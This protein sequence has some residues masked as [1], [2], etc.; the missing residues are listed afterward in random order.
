MV[1]LFGFER[2]VMSVHNQVRVAV[3]ETRNTMDPLLCLTRRRR[4]LL[5]SYAA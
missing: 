4:A 3:R 2:D 1:V 5:M